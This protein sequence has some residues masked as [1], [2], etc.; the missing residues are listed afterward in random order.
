METRF[1]RHKPVT[2]NGKQIVIARSGWSFQGGF[3]LYLDGS[4]YGEFVWD[5]LLKQELI[6]MCGQGA[7]ILLSGLKAVSFHL[8]MMLPWTIRRLRL[9]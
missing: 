9:D 2:I 4:E 7:R 5:M 1:F 6:S 8:A 3:E